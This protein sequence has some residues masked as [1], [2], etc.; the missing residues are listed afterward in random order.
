MSGSE[1]DLQLSGIRLF[2]TSFESLGVRS[3]CTLIETP[4]VKILV[5]PGV[6]LGPRW[7]LL[8]HPM[9]YSAL[10]KAR[11]QIVD[12]AKKVDI[13]TISH[14][15][16]DHYSPA[17]KQ[18]ETVWTWSNKEVSQEIFGGKRVLVK[19]I[20]DKINYSQRRRG[21]FFQDTARRW[22]ESLEV[23]D[24]RSYELGSTTL[25][26]SDPVPHGEDGS[27]LGYLL[28]LCVEHDDERVMHCSDVQGPGSQTALHA[29]LS[30]RPDIAIIGG[31]PFYLSNFRISED[32]ID[33][34]LRNAERAASQVPL[35]V[36]DHHSSRSED[37][38]HR[39][40]RLKRIARQNGHEI[41]TAAEFSGVPNNFLEAKRRELYQE[42]PPSDAFQEWAA[43]SKA[44]RRRRMPPI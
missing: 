33:S 35:I 3:M 39:L 43:L 11:E 16:Y 14:Y 17:W 10:R 13:V 9:E 4:D 5:D 8:P 7:G 12:L 37:C 32:T 25:S 38:L 6:S 41:V 1:A 20:R 30:F 44:K 36:Y 21:W 23:A 29:I 2:P 15:H 26:F 28:M 31:P 22:V 40:S 18:V 24:G 34:A 27:R 19:D 42:N